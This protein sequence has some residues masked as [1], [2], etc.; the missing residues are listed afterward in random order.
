MLIK[1][2]RKVVSFMLDCLEALHEDDTSGQE[3]RQRVKRF[4]KWLYE[5]KSR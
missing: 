3:Y 5:E 1:W 4:H 2:L